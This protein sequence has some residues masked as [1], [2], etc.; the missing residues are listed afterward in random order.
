MYKF[1]HLRRKVSPFCN[2]L[3]V[4]SDTSDSTQ[5]DILSNLH[6]KTS[7]A[8]NEDTGV[9]HALHCFMAQHITTQKEKEPLVL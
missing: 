9:L 7:H 5:D 4:H 3:V 8:R 2:S 1:S 6:S